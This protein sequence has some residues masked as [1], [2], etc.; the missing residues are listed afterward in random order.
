MDRKVRSAAGALRGLEEPV[1]ARG[2]VRGTAAGPRAGDAVWAD[3]REAGDRDHCGRVA[4]GER[5]SGAQPLHAS[6]P[7]D[8]EDEAEEDWH[9]RAGEPLLTA[10]ISA[11]AQRA[12]PVRGSG[13]GELSPPDAERDTVAGGIPAGERAD[14]RQRLGGAV[15]QSVVSG[16]GA[17]PEVRTGARQ[18]GGVSMAG[19]NGRDR[20]SRKKASLEGDSG[21]GAA[22]VSRAEV[23]AAV[24]GCGLR[25]PLNARHKPRRRV[26]LRPQPETEQSKNKQMPKHKKGT[27]LTR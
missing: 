4:A 24:S 5:A 3:V 1:Q 9:A 2:H 25:Y 26:P 13:G 8:Q 6:G 22:R 16:A 21:Y 10:G 11:G 20:I 7:V 14:H 19:R 15:R 17:E 12:V 23:I 18:G 27:F